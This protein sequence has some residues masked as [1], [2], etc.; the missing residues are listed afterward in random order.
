MGGDGTV[1]RIA[2]ASDTV[3]ATIALGDNYYPYSVAISP[4]GTFAYVSNTNR[5]SVSRIDLS[6]NTVVGAIDVGDFPM[7]V[8]FNSDGSKA[9]VANANSGT[10]SEI[11]TATD[12]VV[13]T[14][15][16]IPDR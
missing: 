3:T 7:G 16:E 11:D 4:D 10:V 8:G 1:S 2:T 15:K 13:R 12:A 5:D 9:Y 6:S 14:I